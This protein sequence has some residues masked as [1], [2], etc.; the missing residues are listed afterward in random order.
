MNQAAHPQLLILD[1]NLLRL[2]GKMFLSQGGDLL[3]GIFVLILSGSP[4]I[5]ASESF[6]HRWMTKPSTSEEFD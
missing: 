1:L 5:D 2:S 6:P 4:K 3:E